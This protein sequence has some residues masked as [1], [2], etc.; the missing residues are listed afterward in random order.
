M[1]MTA[2]SRA[3]GVA[4][5]AC[6]LSLSLSGCGKSSSSGEDKKPAS[7][8][9]QPTPVAPE[10]APETAPAKAPVTLAAAPPAGTFMTYNLGLIPAV[11]LEKERLPQIV[12][13]MKQTRAE[14]ACLQEVWRKEDVQAITSGLAGHYPHAFWQE[15]TDD[16]KHQAGVCDLSAAMATK[17]CGA[18]KCT[19]MGISMT[20]CVSDEALCKAQYDG[21]SD[22]CKRCLAANTESPTSCAISQAP[23]IM[24]QGGNGLLLLSW[25][26]IENP[27]YTPM[28]T[29]IVAR[30]AITATVQGKT[31]QCTHLSADLDVVPYPPGGAYTSWAEEHAAQIGIIDKAT[32]GEGC[33]VFLGDMNTGPSVKA[34]EPAKELVGELEE[35]FGAFASAG[36]AEPWQQPVCT[37]CA[38]NP[39]TGVK[40]GRFIDHVFFKGCASAATYGYQRVFDQPIQVTVDGKAVDLRLSDHYGVLVTTTGL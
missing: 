14:V 40:Q 30:G 1:T 6:A 31:V 16:G 38:D 22:E 34:S 23:R 18:E 3:L 26:P 37:F 4:L 24:A 36:Y 28:N 11:G 35:N 5:I 7:P 29:Q 9:E 19:P 2:S 21:F 27:R 17:Q 39:L 12:E 32:E 20:E 25:H 10:A 15:T 13:A 33:R 8:P